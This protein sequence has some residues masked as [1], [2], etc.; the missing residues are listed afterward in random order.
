MPNMFGGDQL[1]EMYAPHTARPPVRNPGP[2][3]KKTHVN[4][5][6]LKANL[7]S[8]ALVL[9][10]EY[11]FYDD[12]GREIQSPMPAKILKLNF[13][14]DH[15]NRTVCFQLT[16]DELQDIVD[17]LNNYPSYYSYDQQPS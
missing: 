1:D 16:K 15:S 12:S 2:P 9:S 5:E 14:T 6:K 11:H 13:Q 10:G 8:N 3:S 17:M 4:V 7:E